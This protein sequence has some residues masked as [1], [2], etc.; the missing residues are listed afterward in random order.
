M[1]IDAKRPYRF[2]VDAQNFDQAF[3]VVPLVAG[4]FHR[5]VRVQIDLLMEKGASFD[6]AKK[7]LMPLAAALYSN[8]RGGL[9]Q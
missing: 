6:E 8:Y 5:E 1:N 3:T 7:V 4:R 2:G 9:Q